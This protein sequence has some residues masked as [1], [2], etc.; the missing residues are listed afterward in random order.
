ML[1]GENKLRLDS[2]KAFGVSRSGIPA[3]I[4]QP[5]THSNV[6]MAVTGLS[7]RRG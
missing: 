7:M 4:A 1:P 2:L 3:S 6:R 5:V